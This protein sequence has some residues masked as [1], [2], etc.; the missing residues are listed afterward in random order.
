MSFSRFTCVCFSTR[1]YFKAIVVLLISVVIVVST[2]NGLISNGNMFLDVGVLTE[3]ASAL[4]FCCSAS[5][6]EFLKS[7]FIMYF[8]NT[9]LQLHCIT[10]AILHIIT[11][12][13]MTTYCVV[14]IALCN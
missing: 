10:A 12:N 3:V 9:V 6:G 2:V 11:V 4:S 5:G 7:E 8:Q 13:A 1:V 14:T